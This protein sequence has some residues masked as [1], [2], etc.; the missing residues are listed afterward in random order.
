MTVVARSVQNA[1]TAVI[2]ARVSQDKSKRLKSVQQQEQ[3]A[4][5]AASQHGWPV[6]RVF[7]DNDRSASRYASKVREE[8]ADLLAHLDTGDVGILILWES[9]RGGRELEGWAGLLNLCRRRGVRIHVVSHRRT[10]DLDNPRD[11]RTLA[12]DGVDSAY[13]SEKTR[14][15]V[16]RDVR[17]NAEKGRPHGKLLYGYRRVYDDRG[18]YIRQEPHPEQA[19]V[20]QEAAQRVRA[21][22]SMYAIARDF[23]A[24]G[25][26][27]PRGGKGWRPEQI[28]RLV[29][30]PGY[31]AKRVH[32]GAVIGD[33]DWPALLSDEIYADCV[34]RLRDPARRTVRDN[35]AKHLLTGVTFCA[36]CDGRMFVQKAPRA[37]DPTHTDLTCRSNFCTSVKERP[38]EEF[39]SNLVLARLSQPDFLDLYAVPGIDGAAVARRQAQELRARLD[40][41]YASAAEGGISPAALASIEARLLPQIQDAENRSTAVAV[42]T[43]LRDAAGPQA[44]E[45]WSR[46]SLDQRRT[47]VRLLVEVRVSRTGRGRR[48]FDPARL[49]QSRWVGDTRTWGEIWSCGPA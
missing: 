12:E 9:S 27:T 23:Q 37:T 29:T 5:E 34:S 24:R 33:A 16:L 1:S 49:E 21:G 40:G 7:R 30:N 14:E 26:P 43:V 45:R 15:R 41:F 11:W 46:L 6:A 8:Y 48:Y 35:R 13:E 36:H 39:V 19:P 28:P 17:A 20:V 10:Y 32:Q 31:V 42:P 25:I 4:R 3:E 2:Y 38:V 44:A 22:E 47:V 18:G